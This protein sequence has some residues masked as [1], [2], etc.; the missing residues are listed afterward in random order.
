MTKETKVLGIVAITIFLLAL[1]ALG[2][3]IYF[4]YQKDAAYEA[5][6]AARD[7]RTATEKDA[8]AL[9]RL[10]AETAAD[11]TELAQY[12]LTEDSVVGFLALIDRLASAG[13]VTWETRSLAVEPI[14]GSDRFEQLTLEV[15]VTGSFAAV[16]RMLSLFESLPYQAEIRSVKISRLN[17][18]QEPPIWRG[19]YR[20]FVTKY[21]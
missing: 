5:G 8:Q 20:L 6:L 16:T 14:A 21:K 19:A 9:G 11:R 13:D 3:M 15:G 18:V 2:A 1:G 10:A 4:V 12:V 17:E 7:V